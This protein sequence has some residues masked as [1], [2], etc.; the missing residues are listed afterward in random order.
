MPTKTDRVPPAPL[1]IINSNFKDN[2]TTNAN[3]Y[4][5]NNQKNFAARAMT[6]I[7]TANEINKFQQN[8]HTLIFYSSI[9]ICCS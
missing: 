3:N 9:F 6:N 5:V 7:A 2:K 4:P 8:K 1:T